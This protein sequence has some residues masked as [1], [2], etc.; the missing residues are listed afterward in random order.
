[1]LVSFTIILNGVILSW[2]YTGHS[3][4]YWALLFTLPMFFI[5]IFSAGKKE[6]APHSNNVGRHTVRRL[7]HSKHNH[8]KTPV[9][10]TKTAHSFQLDNL[11]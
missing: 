4:W 2:A 3:Q 9:R 11:N 10:H 6:R 5:S 8:L 7:K 1:M